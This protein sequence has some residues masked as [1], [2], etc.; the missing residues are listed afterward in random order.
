MSSDR[1]VKLV[2]IGSLLVIVVAWLM[3]EHLPAPE[4]LNPG[5]LEEPDQRP[6]RDKPFDTKV[7]GMDYRIDPRYTYEIAGL[8]VSL[9]DSKAWW[10][11]AHREWGDHINVADLCVVWGENV[12]RDAYRRASFTHTQW[13]CWWS[14][15]AL[16]PEHAFDGASMSNNHVLTDDPDVARR[17]RDVRIGDEVRVRGYLADYTTFKD[18]AARGMRKTS[19][20][21]T[22]E[23]EGACEVIWVQELTIVR[24]HGRGWRIAGKIGAG[25]LV[26]GLIVW[27][28]LPPKLDD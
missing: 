20:V 10:D 8:V 4:K 9:H 2:I 23:G 6:T 15:P 5:T 16:P 17:L 24:S 13:E 11:Y 26:L 18:G 3:A 28:L 21:R 27:I 22:D 14:T 12:R 25:L 7:E 1:L 19:I